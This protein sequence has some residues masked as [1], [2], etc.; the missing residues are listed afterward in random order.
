[1][2]RNKVLV[3][4]DSSD[5]IGIG[6][7]MRCLTLASALMADGAR[8]IFAC[9]HATDFAVASLKKA[10]I[11]LVRPEETDGQT[12]ELCHSHWLGTSQVQDASET[13]SLVSEDH[14]DWVIIDH[15]ALDFRWERHIKKRA[16]RVL[17]IDD[18]SDR[19]HDC[20]VFLNQNIVSKIGSVYS[21]LVNEHCTKL[22]GPKYALLRDEFSVLRRRVDLRIPPISRVLLFFGGGDE[23]NVTAQALE[24]VHNVLVRNGLVGL[25]V[26]V[27]IGSA[28]AAGCS[29]E[30][31]C[32]DFG[33][34]VHVDTMRMADLMSKA[35]IA[36][37]AAGASSWERCC[38]GLP[39]I[40]VSVAE[41]QVNIAKEI[42][43]QGAGLYLG[44]V[45]M[46]K[47]LDFERAI[48]EFLFDRRELSKMSKCAAELTDGQ[49][50]KYV[51]GS[52]E[53]FT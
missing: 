44:P 19:E 14:F 39:T 36:L 31:S 11:E 27:V 18:L 15:Y 8:V 29:I 9:R 41:N 40:L 52:M 46:L 45:E 12:D 30:K 4:T 28:H 26:D 23:L 32:E 48:E 22:I 1:M 42:D 10:D 37:G 51:I 17:V 21:K 47:L 50:V 20:D 49:G 38:L 53:T 25:H 35:D 7:F 6:H 34:K 16:K 33:F 13:C 5:L 24:A 3:R 2:T 43:S